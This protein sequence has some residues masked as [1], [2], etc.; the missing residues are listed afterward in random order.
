MDGQTPIQ[1]YQYGFIDM[2]LYLYRKPHFVSRSIFGKGRA[3]EKWSCKELTEA[4]ETF[5][6]KNEGTFDPN[7]KQIIFAET[8]NEGGRRMD[9]IRINAAAADRRTSLLL[10][11]ST[12]FF[13]YSFASRNDEVDGV[14]FFLTE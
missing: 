10:L 13:A 4:W 7:T 1:R 2:Q 11:I 5:D 8:N 14:L 9:I 12:M 3:R 6:E